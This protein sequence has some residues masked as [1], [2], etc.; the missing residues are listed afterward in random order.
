M[1]KSEKEVD[2]LIHEAFSMEESEYF[3]KLGEQNIPQ[4]VTGLFSG[5][6]AWMNVLIAIITLVVFG[7]TVRSFVEMLN[8]EVI[9]DK[10]E[11][12]TYSILG[13]IAMALLKTWGWNQI[14]K[15]ALLREIKR[16]EFQI[17]LLKK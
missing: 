9:N 6:L 17:S 8:T 10:L 5:R 11:F 13:F 14:D 1:D 3:D 2:K 4:M 15:N 12:M 16:L 7:L